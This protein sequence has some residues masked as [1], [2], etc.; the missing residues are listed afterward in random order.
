VSFLR[1]LTAATA[2]MFVAVAGPPLAYADELPPPELPKPEPTPSPSAPAPSVTPAPTLAGPRETIDVAAAPPAAPMVAPRSTPAAPAPVAAEASPSYP[3]GKPNSYMRFGLGIRVMYAPSAGLDP[4]SEGDAIGQASLE[5][6]R[7]LATSGKLSL[8][9][10]LG[11]DVGMKRTTAR[12]PASG[13]ALHR[14]SVPVEGRYHLTSWLYGFARVA[15]GAAIL[16]V[17]V[18]EPSA[19]SHLSDVNAMFSVDGSAGASFLLGGHGPADRKGVRFWATPEVG[20]GLTTRATPSL[21]PDSRD[22]VLGKELGASTGALS[23]SGFFFR[24]GVGFTY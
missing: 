9:L 18:E 19:P 13:L 3:R 20:Y 1:R 23:V 24:I 5:V 21:T 6:S 22:D 11:W 2:A 14:L 16:D 15:P 8:A 12:G 10:G 7:T 4:F 17:H